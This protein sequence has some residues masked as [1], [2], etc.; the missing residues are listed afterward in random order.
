MRIPVKRM[1]IQKWKEL[2]QRLGG[3]ATY[4]DIP[5]TF[6]TTDSE[7]P[8][9]KG[10]YTDHRKKEIA[11]AWPIDRPKEHQDEFAKEYCSGFYPVEYVE[12]VKRESGLSLIKG[13]K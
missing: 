7:V 12:R 10:V 1:T 13:S 5:P 9:F 2:V 4:V 11:V 3:S 6:T 8:V